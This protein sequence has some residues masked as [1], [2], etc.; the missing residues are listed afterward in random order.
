MKELFFDLFDY[1][2]GQ[3]R[4][5]EVLLANFAG[6]ESDFVRFNHARVRQ[7]MTIR[8]AYLT[9]TLVDGRRR[10]NVTLAVSGQTDADRSALRAAIDGMRTTL[11]SLP[12]DPYLLYSTDVRSSERID[13]GIL[14]AQEQALDTIVTAANDTDLV[15]ILASGPI[16]RGFANSLGQRNW[17]AVASCNFEWS[18]YHAGDKAV[19]SAWAASS[20]DG[21]ALAARIEDS[22]RQLLHLARPPHTIEP[23]TY[24]T[25]LAPAALDELLWL[26]NWGGVSSKAQRTKQSPLQKLV[27]G[28]AALSS[29]VSLR[30]NTAD[31]LTPAFDTMGF[32]KPGRVELIL[33]GRHADSMV[34]PRTAAEYDIAA[35]GADDEEGMGS[36]DVSAGALANDTALTALDTG[37]YVGNLWYLNYSDRPNC[38]I[39]G[40]TRFATFWVEDGQIRAP[41]D[42]MRFDDSLY[43]MLGE[44]L[45]DFTR[46]REWILNTGTYGRRSVE[47]SRLPGALLSRVTFTL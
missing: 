18:I 6:E 2:N 34:S 42:V 15:G 10:D 35:N 39:T 9:L 43:R 25:Y 44:N 19:K 47:T 33:E 41:L 29:K 22:R 11:P 3:L 12:E 24:R 13:T 14:P 46:E 28:E 32:V 7:A 4:G 45:V 16:V 37:V 26:L 8:Q 5:A 40:M 31:G 30:E 38:R 23:G 1:A 21:D 36:M 20:W 17:H 27:D